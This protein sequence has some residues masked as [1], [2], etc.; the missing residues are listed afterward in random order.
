MILRLSD[1]QTMDSPFVWKAQ[2]TARD[3]HDGGHSHVVRIVV[4]DTFRI[5]GRKGIRAQDRW[6]DE[7][8]VFSCSLHGQYLFDS[9]QYEK[10]PA[11]SIETA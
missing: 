10:E 9:R 1:L 11:G 3:G 8:A 4:E 5:S 2:P 7:T 6:Q